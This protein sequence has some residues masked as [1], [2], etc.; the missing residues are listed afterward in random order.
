MRANLKNIPTEISQKNILYQYFKKLF[1][2]ILF[3]KCMINIINLVQVKN[4]EF[5]IC[6]FFRL[7]EKNLFSKSVH[8][9]R[10]IFAI[11]LILGYVNIY[12]NE[13]TSISGNYW[14]S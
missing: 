7:Q 13:H 6:S 3:C 9:L 2:P 11:S 4:I 5:T 1:L 10:Q 14:L 8:S 12:I